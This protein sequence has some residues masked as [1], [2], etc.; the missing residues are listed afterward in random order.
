M[1]IATGAA[2][3]RGATF[4]G[5]WPAASV[6]GS[7]SSGT[8]VVGLRRSDWLGL[9]H[10]LWS[11]RGAGMLHP[12]HQPAHRRARHA[13]PVA[14][15][16]PRQ[17]GRHQRLNALEVGGRVVPEGCHATRLYKA[18]R[19]RLDRSTPMRK[20]DYPL[21]PHSLK[22]RQAAQRG[23]GRVLGA[24]AGLNPPLPDCYP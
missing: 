10:R 9:L 15:L 24:G 18:E 22:A 21:P 1:P 19:G 2:E 17:A 23:R 5:N 3:Q 16:R 13:Q 12:E 6:V 11:W 4:A 7:S 20:P 14:D 8:A